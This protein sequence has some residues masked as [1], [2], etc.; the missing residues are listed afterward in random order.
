[1][2]GTKTQTNIPLGISLSLVEVI[3]SI[4]IAAL[5]KLIA[6]DLSVLMVLLKNLVTVKRLL[7]NMVKK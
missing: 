7:I 1:M 6:G 4:S 5:V 2:T 3:C